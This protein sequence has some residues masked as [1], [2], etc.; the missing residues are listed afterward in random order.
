MHFHSYPFDVQQ[1]KIN[2]LSCKYITVEAHV[3]FVFIPKLHV[4]VVGLGL[5]CLTP[6]ST[7]FQPDRG[8]QCYQKTIDLSQITD[9]LY[10]IIRCDELNFCKNLVNVETSKEVYGSVC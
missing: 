5:W 3:R 10:H 9:T 6:L 7:V 1:C 8:C 2:I 4:E